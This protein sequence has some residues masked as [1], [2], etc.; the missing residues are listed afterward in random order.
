LDQI[1]DARF[2]ITREDFEKPFIDIQNVALGKLEKEKAAAYDRQSKQVDP[3]AG[4]WG[5]VIQNVWKGLYTYPKY[6][7][8]LVNPYSPLPE[9]GGWKTEEMKEKERIEDML[10]FDPKEL[11]RYNK[12]RGLDPDNP[13][14]WEAYKNLKSI[15]PGLGFREENAGG[16]IA[17]IRRP[18][19]IPP[20][21]G[22]D[23]QGLAYLN[24]YATKR[25]E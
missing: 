14:T 19:A 2:D 9:L 1:K 13:I 10:D 3:E 22:P 4:K 11:Y 23:S 6:A 21:S 5:E 8:D 16:G 12:A 17:G 7:F 15:H 24:N 20:E 25:T 18:W